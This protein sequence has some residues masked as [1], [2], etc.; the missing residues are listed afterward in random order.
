[1]FDFARHPHPAGC[2]QQ[3]LQDGTLPVS[4]TGP[5]HELAER[6]FDGDQTWYSDGSSQHRDI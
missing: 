6:M 2:L 3:T 4:V 1:M 5:A